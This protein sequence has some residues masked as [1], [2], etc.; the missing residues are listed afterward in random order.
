M[1][2]IDDLWLIMNYLNDG[3]VDI[4]LSELT[5][6]LATSEKEL[7]ITFFEEIL[8]QSVFSSVDYNRLRS[9][10]IDWYSSHRTIST[11]QKN[12]SDVH[13]LP[14]THLSELFKS[15]GFPIGLNLVPLTAKANFFL[16]L[17]TLLKKKGTP[18]TLISVLDYYGFSDSDLIEYW[19]ERDTYSNFVFKGQS[20]RQATSGSTVLLDTD[21]P[22]TNMTQ[23]DPH[24]LINESQLTNLVNN[25]H[26]NLPSKSPYFSLSSIFYLHKLNSSLSIMSRIVQDQYD[27]YQSGLPLPQ[28]I[29][30]KNLGINA[31]LLE[32]YLAATYAYEEIFGSLSSTASLWFCCYD[33]TVNYTGDPPIPTNLDNIAQEYE[34]LINIVPVDRADRD[35]RIATYLDDWA[36]LTST[37]FLGSAP[38]TA[39]DI[40]TIINPTLKDTC[41]HWIGSGDEEYLITYLIGTLDDWIRLNIDSKSPSLVITLIGLSFRD[42]INKIINF[43]KPYRARL[44][45]IDT[46]Y[47]IQNRLLESVLLDE[48]INQQINTTF[49]DSTA[50]ITDELNMNVYM[51]FLDNAYYECVGQHI[52]FYDSGGV[53]D[54][55]PA[56]CEY[57]TVA[58]QQILGSST[59]EL[60]DVFDDLQVTEFANLGNE[61]VRGAS[62]PAMYDIGNRYDTPVQAPACEDH[63]EITVI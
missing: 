6:T 27:R 53:Y 25:N 56:W 31:S 24:W 10:I 37:N 33:G 52:P 49:T 32:A 35:S 63:I 9:F 39:K 15:F 13:T 34:D 57:I 19:V 46:S 20:V 50:I 60:V 26:I 58:L 48:I 18:E 55:L 11:T 22:F 62:G 38:K 36:R 61:Y 51:D 41:D 12:A 45:F 14:N 47:A 4:N 21:V 59:T 42:D 16:D 29:P 44:V 7:V 23:N 2:T 54:Q 30:I 17:V 1:F 3:S 5:Q 40:L 43:F 28:N 8:D